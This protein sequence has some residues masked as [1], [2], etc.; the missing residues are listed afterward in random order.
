M[1]MTLV[2]PSALTRSRHAHTRLPLSLQLARLFRPVSVCLPRC[3]VCCRPCMVFYLL[4]CVVPT[5][6]P[7]IDPSPLIG[8]LMRSAAQSR[9]YIYNIH[10]YTYIYTL[11]IYI[12]IYIYISPPLACMFV[13]CPACISPI[14]RL[15]LTVCLVSRVPVSIIYTFIVQQ[16]H[17][18]PLCPNVSSCIR[19][20]LAV[21]S[22]VPLYLPYPTASK[23]T[24]YS[25][26]YTLGEGY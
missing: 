17:C 3:V 13:R 4:L 12:Y 15:C 5:L 19:S 14:F 22:C 24:G 11:Y 7:P 9:I 16:I 20:Y 1:R 18:I 21:S 25:Q 8:S 26:K 6:S 2:A 23:T 10:T